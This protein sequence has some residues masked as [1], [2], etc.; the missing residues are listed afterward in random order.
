MS[1]TAGM[2]FV[3]AQGSFATG[4]NNMTIGRFLATGSA[5]RSATLGTSTLSLGATSAGAII[6][7]ATSGLTWSASSATFTISQASTNARSLDLQGLTIGTLN[8]NVANSPGGLTITSSGTITTLTVGSGRLFTVTAGQTLTVT[9]W[10]VSGTP[11][12]YV[13]MPGDTYGASIPDSAATSIANDIDVR[14][15]VAI[16]DITLSGGRRIAAKYGAAGQRS[17]RFYISGGLPVFE[18]SN[19]GTATAVAATSTATLTAAGLS[20]GTTY[21]LR[22]ARDQAG[23]TVKFYYAADSTSV[24]SGASWTQIGSTLTS[25]STAA[26]FDSTTVTT[27]GGEQTGTNSNPGR[28]YRMQV[29]SNL[30]DN[31]SAIQIDADLTAKAFGANTFTESSSNA[32]TVT[33]NGSSVYGDGRVSIN[34]SSAGSA[35]TISKS[36]TNISSDYLVI[37]DSTVSTTTPGYAGANSVDVSGNTNWTFSAPPANA[38]YGA[39]MLLGVG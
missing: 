13:Y 1:A 9:N 38:Q 37:K 20:S 22:A 17:W 24:P 33:M 28:Y 4:N 3:V 16:D 5:T 12:G 7:L 10:S 35:G 8:Y 36:G 29:C 23:G 34:S 31:G 19:D 30:L 25:M 15:R 18:T 11:N 21:W 26:T 2:S 14:V 6:A 39:L 27:I 32:A